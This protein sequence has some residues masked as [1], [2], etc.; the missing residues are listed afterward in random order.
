MKKLIITVFFTFAAVMQVLAGD[1][2]MAKVGNVMVHDGWARASL[3]KAPNSAAYMSLMTHGDEADKLIGAATPVAEAAELHN[4]VMDGDI[5]KMRS[6]D[7]IEIRPGD[8]VTLEPGGFHIMLM[9]LKE[10]LEEGQTL[11][12]TLTFENA[13]DVKVDVPILSLKAG[14]KHDHSS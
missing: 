6:V 5:A 14:M 13:G 3:G 8:P 2:G 4:H 7:A 12:L 9:G 10:K 1:A 11:P